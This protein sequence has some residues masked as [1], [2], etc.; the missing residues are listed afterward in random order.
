VD[1]PICH[2]PADET[3]GAALVNDEWSPDVLASLLAAVIA[4]NRTAEELR[5]MT[6]IAADEIEP[7]ITYLRD[8]N[9]ITGIGAQH[10]H[11]SQALCAGPC[12]RGGRLMRGEE[13]VINPKTF[14]WMCAEC[15]DATAKPRGE[16]AGRDDDAA[17]TAREQPS[18]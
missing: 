12:S 4:S 9:R 16:T 11:A 3:R 6:G 17:D 18:A 8:K 15:W 2:H 10:Y 1:V 14:R 7:A 5:D 13:V